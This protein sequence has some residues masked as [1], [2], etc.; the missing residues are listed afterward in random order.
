MV[1]ALSAFMSPSQADA[2]P[3]SL[4]SEWPRQYVT[5]SSLMRV[6]AQHSLHW[7]VKALQLKCAISLRVSTL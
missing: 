7:A 4:L 6:V 2:M 1:M 3:N 5:C